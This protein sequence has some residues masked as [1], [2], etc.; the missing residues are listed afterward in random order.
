MS[1]W[2]QVQ[3][4]N[5][6]SVSMLFDTMTPCRLMSLGHMMENKSV[7]SVLRNGLPRYKDNTPLQ[8]VES[9]TRGWWLYTTCVSYFVC[10]VMCV[11]QK[12]DVSESVQHNRVLQ[13]GRPHLFLLAPLHGLAPSPSNQPQQ[14]IKRN[15]QRKKGVGWHTDKIRNEIPDRRKKTQKQESCK[16]GGR[17]KKKLFL[18][19]KKTRG[20][21]DSQI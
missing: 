21:T 12:E 6:P 10:D 17:E 7:L 5:R 8:G 1:I 19:C 15:G 16:T 2:R 9:R 14:D 4:K 11:C 18:L 3:N 20:L 13:C